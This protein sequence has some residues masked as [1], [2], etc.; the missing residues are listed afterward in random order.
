MNKNGIII[1]IKNPQ[2]GKVKT[3]LAAT[4]GNERALEIYQVLLNHTQKI[5]SSLKVEKFLFYSDFIDENDIWRNEFYHKSLQNPVE[6]LG[7][8]MADAFT[9]LLDDGFEK[10]LIIGSDCLELT[11][12]ILIT[13]FDELAD[14]EVVIG[15][16]LDGGYYLIGFN[17]NKIGERSNEVLTNI[18]LN[19]QWSHNEVYKEA[20]HSFEV[21]N[22]KYAQLT[23]LTDIDEEKDFLK[24]RS[25]LDNQANND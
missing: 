3:R 18:F 24:M 12:D 5:T 17:F 23:I 16:A 11:T 8:K 2:L 9:Q 15:P 13:A 1:F 19:K 21:L 14:N 22:L 7:F 6:D 20:M 10:A 4:V 25:I